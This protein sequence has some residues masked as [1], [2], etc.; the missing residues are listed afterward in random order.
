[1]NI[2]IDSVTNSKIPHFKIGC[3]IYHN[4]TV[5]DSP[6][7][8]K[9]KFRSLQKELFKHAQLKEIMDFSGIKEWRDTFKLAG[10][11]ASRYRHSAEALYRRI[12][13]QSFLEPIH[14]AIDVNNFFSL[15]YECPLGIYDLNQIE[16]NITLSIGI[17]NDSYEGINGRIN[18]MK[19]IIL[20][21]DETGAFGSPYVDSK[22]TMVTTETKNA[23]QFIYLRPSLTLE[24]AIEI[25]AT[26]MKEFLEIHGGQGQYEILT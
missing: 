8:F 12:K 9:E 25:T 19:N 24:E 17:D 22:R 3:I 1:M 26:V 7:S 18:N 21:K 6:Q 16:G 4:I 13:K 15:L 23:I 20:S 11:D 5:S 14:S 10:T 2:L